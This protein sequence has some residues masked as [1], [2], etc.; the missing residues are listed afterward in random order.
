M[1]AGS[2]KSLVFQ[3]N[4]LEEVAGGLYPFFLAVH[5]RKW[6]SKNII[7]NFGLKRGI[8]TIALQIVFWKKDKGKP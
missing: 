5:G 7:E 1:I 3:G 6:K 4:L 8:L 2:G